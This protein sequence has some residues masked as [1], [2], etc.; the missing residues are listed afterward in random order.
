MTWDVDKAVKYSRDHAKPHSIG[1]CAKYTREAIEAGGIKL[2]RHNS[3]KDYG[4]SLKAVGFAP[5]NFCPIGYAK[6]D[7]AIFQGFKG[8]PH[9]HIQMYDGT[10]WISDFKQKGFW[11]GSSFQKANVEYVVY[12]YRVVMPSVPSPSSVFGWR[13]LP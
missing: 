8:H 5:L 4:S 11:P 3:A 12:R 2:I 10:Q 7:V 1:M 6:G 9:G 13:N